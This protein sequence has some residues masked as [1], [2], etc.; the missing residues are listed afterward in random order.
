MNLGKPG[1]TRLGEPLWA[2]DAASPLVTELEAFKPCL[3]REDFFF[4]ETIFVEKLIVFE[5]IV[6]SEKSI[7]ETLSTD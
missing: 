2:G 6:F 7:V 5:K 1:G 4:A 3:V